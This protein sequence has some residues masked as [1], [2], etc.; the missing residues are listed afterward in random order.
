MTVSKFEGAA[1]LGDAAGFVWAMTSSAC[2]GRLA[3]WMWCP[4]QGEDRLPCHTGL[5]AC[6]RIWLTARC[7]LP[8][9]LVSDVPVLQPGCYLIICLRN[10]AS[11][12]GRMHDKLLAR[13]QARLSRGTKSR[14]S[15]PV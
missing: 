8:V 9:L 3:P 4:T 13:D 15:G 12:A 10:P 5:F 14:L 7:V 6:C 2:D 1:V 11:V